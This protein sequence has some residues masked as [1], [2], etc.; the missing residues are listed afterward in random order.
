MGGKIWLKNQKKEGK[1]M[2][3][4]K[5]KYVKKL[6]GAGAVTLGA[7]FLI[8][9]IYHFGFEWNDFL[10]HEWL[11]VYLIISGILAGMWANKFQKKEKKK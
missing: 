9:H 1:I 8:E 10:G 5:K 4:E 11:G 6:Y 2:D 7:Y 3:E